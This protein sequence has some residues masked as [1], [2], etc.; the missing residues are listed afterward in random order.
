M[1]PDEIIIAQKLYVLL[2]NEKTLHWRCPVSLNLPEKFVQFRD[3][4]TY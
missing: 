1:G 4:K 2:S 3:P